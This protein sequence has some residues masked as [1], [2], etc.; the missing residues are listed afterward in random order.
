MRPRSVSP[1]GGPSRARIA[2]AGLVVLAL[3][4][5]CVPC[6][7]ALGDPLIRG[8][9]SDGGGPGGART[10]WTARAAALLDGLLALAA[11][12]YVQKVGGQ[13]RLEL[14]SF[15]GRDGA[16]SKAKIV[17]ALRGALVGAWL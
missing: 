6:A 17:P 16:A 7:S 2:L 8:R 3:L 4:N 10:S 11:P 15:A 14:L 13:L 1:R 12:V 9:L 5:G